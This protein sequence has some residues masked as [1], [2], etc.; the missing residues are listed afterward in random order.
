MP[1]AEVDFYPN[2][3]EEQES[4]E[5]FRQLSQEVKWQQDKIKH[6]GKEIDL[7]RLTA[8]YGD[9]GKSY[10]YSHIA[11]KSEPWTPVLLYI[12]SRIEEVV[13][14]SFNS[15]LLNLYRGGKDSVSWH[16]DNERELGENPVISSVSFG[17]VRRFQLR[18]KLKKDVSKVDLNLTPGSLLVMKGR[19]QQFWQHQ[20]PKTSKPVLPRINLTF[21][22]IKLARQG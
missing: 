21:R 13:E 4:D 3:F 1:D 7:P 14:V 10:T 5:L 16:Q 22:V 6:Y 12:K 11:M 17:G 9:A 8:W 20:V 15:V 18:H 19:T 2:F